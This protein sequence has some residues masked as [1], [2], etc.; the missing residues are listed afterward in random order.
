MKKYGEE[1]FLECSSKGDKRFSAFYARVNGRSI[2]AQ[3][4]GAKVFEDGST[5]LH[6][7]AAKG[8]RAVNLK[9][10]TKLYDNLWV[11]YINEHPELMEVLRT[12][13]GLCDKFARGIGVNQARTLWKIRCR[14]L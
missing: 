14:I 7:R 1:P 12:S 4:Q 10:V 5:G 6:W 3:F 8:K 11:Q 9:E 2:E 13:S